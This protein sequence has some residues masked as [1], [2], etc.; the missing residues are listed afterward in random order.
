MEKA[1]ARLGRVGCLEGSEDVEFKLGN[2]V[3]SFFHEEKLYLTHW[4]RHEASLLPQDPA[5]YN[6][7]IWSHHTININLDGL[8]FNYLKHT[9][10]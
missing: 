8:C 6:V 9:S 10:S 4:M 3:V 5:H 1:A 7:S 2:L